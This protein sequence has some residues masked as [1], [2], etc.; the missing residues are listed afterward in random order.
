MR[1][2]ELE[3]IADELDIDQAGAV[4]HINQDA[5]AAAYDVEKRK[6]FE[7]TYKVNSSDALSIVNKFGK[8]SVNTWNKSEIQVKVDIIARCATEARAVE[9]LDKINV[10]DNREG[11]TI[12]IVT[13]MEPMRV[14]GNNNRSFEINYTIYMPESNSLAV[15]NSFGDV[16]LASLKGKTNVNVSYGALK[17]E[18]L[19]NSD[20]Y[21]KVAYGSGNCGYINGGNVNLAYADVFVGGAN[22]LKG[23]ASYGNFKIG[24]LTEEMDIDFK[25]GT[26]KVDNVSKDIK[27]IALNSN[28]GSVSLNFADNSS[29]NFDVNVSFGDFKV[30]R[31]LINLTTMEKGYTSAEY[32]GKFGGTSPKGMVNITSKFG[33]VKFTK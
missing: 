12:S 16:Q 3:A 1:L 19:S 26:F 32:K 25:H 23:S 4:T 6:T 5:D 20:N 8:V 28:Y 9:L 21:V 30:D 13:K 14:S 24:Q 27:K 11:N 31:S 7:K 33:D 2:S 17:T 10:V 29:F 15:K 22:G 18:R